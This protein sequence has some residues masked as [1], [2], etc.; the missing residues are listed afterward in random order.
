LGLQ[1]TLETFAL[2][3]V[4]RLLAA[5]RKTGCLHVEGDRGRGGVWLHQGQLVQVMVENHL[6]EAPVVDLL[7]ELLRLEK[8]S[9]SF[10]P[11]DY[12]QADCTQLEDLEGALLRAT[13]LLMEW[14][15]LATV[16]PSLSH[17][18]VLA[19]H[20]NGDGVTLDAR[21]WKIVSAIADGPGVTQLAERL[22]L[23]EM[24]VLRTICDAVD[25]GV[26]VIEPPG[27]LHTPAAGA[28]R[29]TGQHPAAPEALSADSTANGAGQYAMPASQ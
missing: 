21:R 6:A 11:A 28:R 24:D 5:T 3:D 16:V 7:F 17:Q 20:L 12:P 26:A 27:A 4:L 13:D 23:G 10:V 8:G 29:D 9:F 22:H 14:Q 25:L 2:P 1:G 15:D 19:P 18:V